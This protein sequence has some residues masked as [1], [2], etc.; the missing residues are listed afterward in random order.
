M[1]CR[2]S[3]QIF[4]FVIHTLLV[5]EWLERFELRWCNFLKCDLEVSLRFMRLVLDERDDWR[6]YQ[7][8]KIGWAPPPRCALS[9]R[10][11]PQLAA[12]EPQNGCS[13]AQSNAC[14]FKL[15]L[16]GARACWVRSLPWDISFV[17]RSAITTCLNRGRTQGK[18]HTS[19]SQ[20]NVFYYL[21]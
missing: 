2:H 19:L 11:S 18:I 5:T 4:P 9:A 14:I 1:S 21:L 12:F 15:L 8:N 10:V 7:G 20:K 17:L 6:G 3:C 16:S 13:I